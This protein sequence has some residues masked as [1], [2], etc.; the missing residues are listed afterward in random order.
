MGVGTLRVGPQ[1]HAGEIVAQGIVA[2]ILR[3]LTKLQQVPT[4]TEEERGENTEVKFFNSILEHEM[5]LELKSSK[6]SSHHCTYASP[7]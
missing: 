4:G 2:H 5:V 7:S 3:N 1:R 6:H